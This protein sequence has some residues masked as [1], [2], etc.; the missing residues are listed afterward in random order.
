M[1][2]E[3]VG[4]RDVAR[5]AGVSGRTVSHVLNDVTGARRG[6]RDARA[7]HEAASRLDYAPNRMAAR[8]APNAP[9]SSG[10]S[11]TSS[12]KDLRPVLHADHPRRLAP[13]GQFSGDAAG[14]MW[15]AT[16]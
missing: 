16:G 8:C 6:R 15:A 12:P 13:G 1:P 5:L 2:R 10:W 7:Y 14:S 11:A 3:S 4:I 9:G